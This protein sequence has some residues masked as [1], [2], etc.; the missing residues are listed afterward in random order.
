MIKACIFDLDG[1]LLDTI[2]SIRYYLNKTLAVYGIAPI[3]R[4]QTKVFVGE[5]ALNLTKRA[6]RA[7][8]VD[9][10]SLEGMSLSHR[11]CEEYSNEYDKNPFYLTEP[12]HGITEAVSLLKDRGIK[13]AVISNKPDSTVKQLVKNK[14]PDIFD[15][16]EGAMPERPLKPDPTS[17]LSICERLS[18][19]PCETVYFGDTATDMKTA[20]NYGAK[21]AAGV[22]WGFREREELL[23]AG[24]D[25]LLSSADEIIITDDIN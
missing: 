24:A 19:L 20:K 3:T 10:D 2:E 23:S 6:L 9:T 14:F 12:Y 11:I 15:I 7:D 5:G 16:V 17:V 13:L 8:G 18:V 1:T 22:L 4:E 21:I 25:I